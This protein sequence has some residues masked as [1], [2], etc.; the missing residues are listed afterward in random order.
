MARHQSYAAAARV[1]RQP[2]LLAVVLGERGAHVGGERELGQQAGDRGV[3]E[4]VDDREQSEG[5]QLAGVATG[6]DAPANPEN[7]RR[8]SAVVVSSAGLPSMLATTHNTPERLEA[9]DS[10]QREGLPD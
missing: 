3:Y 9:L 8:I 5:E 4:R 7:R 6:W 10:G 2:P 1:A